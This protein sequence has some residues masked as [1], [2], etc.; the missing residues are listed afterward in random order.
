[1]DEAGVIMAFLETQFLPQTANRA[2][3]YDLT[4]RSVELNSSMTPA[5]INHVSDVFYGSVSW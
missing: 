3:V 5:F 1:M 2:S 4:F